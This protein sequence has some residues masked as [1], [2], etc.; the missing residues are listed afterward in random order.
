MLRISGAP[1]MK[2]AKK[3]EEAKKLK[4]ESG[5]EVSDEHIQR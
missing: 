3:A 2:M 4:V 5:V 1:L